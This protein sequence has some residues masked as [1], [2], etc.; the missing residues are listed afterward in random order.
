MA[1]ALDLK[2][3]LRDADLIARIKVVSTKPA[4]T[5]SRYKQLALATITDGIK[6]PK[7]GDTIQ[8]LSDNGSICPNVLYGAN[9]DCIIFARRT[10][11]GYYETMN[12]YAGQFRVRDG[13][14]EDCYLFRRTAPELAKNAKSEAIISAF[15]RL[16]NTPNK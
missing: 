6:G 2:T 8:L 15:R 11:E 3:A 5:G 10:P 4:P 16:I 1:A 13:L 12:T 7:A 9:D 14:V